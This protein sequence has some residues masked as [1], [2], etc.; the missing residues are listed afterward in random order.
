MNTI[1]VTRK[2]PDAGLTLLKKQ[3]DAR[4]RM[5][6]HNRVLTR[7]ELLRLVNGADA[8]LS[9]LTDRIDGE[10][11]DAAGKQLKIIANYAVGF[12]NIDLA[13][14]K[15]RGIAVT[16]TPAPLITEAVAEHS[17][18]LAMALAHRLVEADVFTRAGKYKGWSPD[19]FIGT[20]LHEKTIGIVGMGRIGQA[21]AR[22]AVG[23]GMHVLYTGP[24]R[25][26]EVEQ[27]FKARYMKTLSQLLRASDVVTIHVPL[28]P[29]TRHL[30][31]TKEFSAMRPSAFLV[32]TSRGPI[33]DERALLA[34]LARKKIA[35]AAL[36]VFECE[37]SIDCD[38]TDHRAL[39][40]FSNVIL[41]PHIASATTEARDEMAVLAAQNILAVLR[42]KKPLNPAR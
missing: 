32:N 23:L 37:P 16:N 26:P 35:G 38:I 6:P 9:L 21:V 24:H 15:E 3:K 36:D 13:A 1:V 14:A 22:R 30:M 12:D 17:I 39:A 8:I 40:N 28:L 20:Q 4:V 7:P 29:T 33:V 5:N 42:G 10:I 19:L 27:Q 25:D 31:S 2:I 18:A 41:T 34:V 11:M